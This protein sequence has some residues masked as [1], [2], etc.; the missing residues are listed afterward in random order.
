MFNRPQSS[1]GSTEIFIRASGP[2]AVSEPGDQR[3]LA[4]EDLGTRHQV[5][6]N[7]SLQVCTLLLIPLRFSTCNC[8]SDSKSEEDEEEDVDSDE[9]E[10][11]VEGD[12]VEKWPRS[13]TGASKRKLETTQ[14]PDFMAKRFSAFQPYRDATLQKWYDKT[15]L[16]TGKNN[17]VM[18]RSFITMYRTCVYTRLSFHPSV[19]SSIHISTP[20]SILS[21]IGPCF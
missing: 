17:K 13:G 12:E 19:Y 9:G 20:P 14:Y 1:E 15:R 11:E 3:H 18:E 6:H 7:T 4:G 21:S 2:A 10:N 5:P 8:L 16:T